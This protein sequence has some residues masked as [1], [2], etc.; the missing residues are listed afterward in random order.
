[1]LRPAEIVI[2]LAL[3]ALVSLLILTG[4]P[5]DGIAPDALPFGVQRDA[6][7]LVALLAATGAVMLAE[8]GERQAEARG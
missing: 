2:A 1:M 3:V 6:C 8:A 4:Q 5:A 7:F